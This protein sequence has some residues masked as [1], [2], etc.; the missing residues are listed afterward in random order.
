MKTDKLWGVS[1]LLA[2]TETT[3]LHRILINEN[4]ESSFH[5]HVHK[6]NLIYVESGKL[7][8]KHEDG[9]TSTLTAGSRIIF[10][11][12][13]KHKFKALTAC[14]AYEFYWVIN[15]TGDIVRQ[16]E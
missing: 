13:E 15:H 11:P 5:H 14:I 16:C 1:E 4:G 6:F 10:A 9:T 12:G 8:I 7:L 2:K 3:E